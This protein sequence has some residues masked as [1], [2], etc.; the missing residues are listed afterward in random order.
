MYG[1]FSCF[2]FTED[3]I[4]FIA[5]ELMAKEVFEVALGGGET[6][7]HPDFLEILKIFNRDNLKK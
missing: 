5:N 1:R 7:L 3:N 2:I 4:K 6:T